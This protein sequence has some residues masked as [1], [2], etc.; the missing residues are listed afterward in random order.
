MKELVS[1]NVT[2]IR[3]W[4]FH[5]GAKKTFGLQVGAENYSEKGFRGL[6]HVIAQAERH[7]LKLILTLVNYWPEYGGVDQYLQWHNLPKGRQEDRGAFFIDPELRAHFK[8][9][10]QHVVSRRNQETGR[11]YKEEPSILGWELMNEGRGLGASKWLHTMWVQEMT[12]AL[13]ATGVKQLLSTGGSGYDD[14]EYSDQNVEDVVESIGKWTLDGSMEVSYSLNQQLVDF[15]TVHCYPEAWNVSKKDGERS[16]R[17]WIRL[18]GRISRENNR[19]TICTEIAL[20]NQEQ[21]SEGNYGLAERRS[22]YRSWMKLAENGELAGL[23]PWLYIPD[24][25]PESWDKHSFGLRNESLPEDKVNKYTDLIK[26][27]GEAMKKSV[28]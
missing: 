19:P 27:H 8:R 20:V 12:D 18:H 11:Y 24:K 13:R 4:A 10:I 5:D 22:I 25:R 26:D 14:I 1:L 15:G 2:V 17:A 9:H 28:R 6:D 21:F 3:T 16:C 23:L 7:G